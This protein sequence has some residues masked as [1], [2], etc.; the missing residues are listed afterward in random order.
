MSRVG[1]SAAALVGVSFAMAPA[2]HAQYCG[3]VEGTSTHDS[4]LLGEVIE[5]IV[6]SGQTVYYR[7]GRLAV[8]RKT[9]SSF[10]YTEIASCE[11]ITQF[12]VLVYAYQGSDV[13]APVVD[14]IRCGVGGPHIAPF[15][16]TIFGFG[17]TVLGDATLGGTGGDHIFGTQNDDH[18]M[19]L[20]GGP[21]SSDGAGDLLCGYE[22]NDLLIGD[23]SPTRERM[24]G[25]A[26]Q[27]SCQGGTESSSTRI[28]HV[29]S[30]ETVWPHVA[31]QSSTDPCGSSVPTWTHTVFP[32]SSLV[33][34][35]VFCRST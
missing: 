17:I 18:L 10:F 14:T 16:E 2:S 13:V 1:W 34:D 9:G 33:C 26:G 5:D 28:D 27:D 7:G 35:S 15:A 30:C 20:H 4:I 3:V 6:I 32:D 8:C 21:G 19:S 29:W 11:D 23:S 12:N 31:A 24:S 25:G 22:G